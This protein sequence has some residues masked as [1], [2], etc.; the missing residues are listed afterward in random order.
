[1]DKEKIVS[2]LIDYREGNLTASQVNEVAKKLEE[3]K[4][5]QETFQELDQLEQI[6]EKAP[7]ILPSSSSRNRFEQLLAQEQISPTLQIASKTPRKRGFTLQ[8]VLQVA[9]AITLLIMGM[10]IGLQWKNNHVQQQELAAL[11]AEMIVQ[12]KLL[13]LSLLEQNSASDRIKGINVSLE[14]TNRDQEIIQ[15]LIQ[16]MNVDN[17][18]NVRLK[19]IEGLTQFG[20][21]PLVTAAFIKALNEQ[22]LPEVQIAIMEVLVELQ[23]KSAYPSFKKILKNEANMEAVR[24]KAA[25]GLSTL[26]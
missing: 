15:A 12:K 21:Q 19:A 9:A 24:N 13:A 8:Q 25:S 7:T 5:W 23:I 3:Q 18:I 20:N 10:G 22:N 26:L 11:R 4:I 16:R 17:N 6:M 1:M 2:Q 14:E